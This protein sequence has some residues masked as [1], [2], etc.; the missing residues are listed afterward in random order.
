MVAAALDDDSQVDVPLADLYEVRAGLKISR[1]HRLFVARDIDLGRELGHRVVARTIGT[2]ARAQDEG[3]ANEM[4]DAESRKRFRKDCEA[5][6]H[7][8][9]QPTPRGGGSCLQACAFCRN[10]RWNL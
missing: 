3:G 5:F 4:P 8:H 9:L 2:C 1:D 10:C 6:A 7:G